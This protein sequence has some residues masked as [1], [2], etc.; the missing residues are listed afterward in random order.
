MKL[1]KLFYKIISAVLFCTI[2]FT[3]FASFSFAK[4]QEKSKIRNYQTVTFS[5]AYNADSLSDLK[6]N[7]NIDTLFTLK[8][9]EIYLQN[10]KFTINRYITIND[11]ELSILKKSINIPIIIL[12]IAGIICCVII[13]FISVLLNRDECLITIPVIIF[14]VLIASN[15]IKECNSLEQLYIEQ[16]KEN[17]LII[18]TVQDKDNNI[19]YNENLTN[20]NQNSNINFNYDG[21]SYSINLDNINF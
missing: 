15:K 3:S 9:K 17:N 10:T 16:A 21:Q 2:F 13:T 7:K 1:N 6:I 20:Y 4:E 5:E 11:Y 18:Y 19:I 14:I 12:W 8:S